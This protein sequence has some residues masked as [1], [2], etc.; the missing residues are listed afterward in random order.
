MIRIKHIYDQPGKDD[1]YEKNLST[2]EMK[3]AE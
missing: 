3:R 1:A 2:D